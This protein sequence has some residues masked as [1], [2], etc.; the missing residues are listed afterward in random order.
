V[1]R[2]IVARLNLEFL[3]T[4]L[5]IFA[6]WQWVFTHFFALAFPLNLVWL[7]R[8][9]FKLR[10]CNVA[11]MIADLIGIQRINCSRSMSASNKL[12]VLQN[13]GFKRFGS[14]VPVLLVTRNRTESFSVIAS[15][16]GNVGLGDCY[17]SL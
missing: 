13:H 15:A 17:I 2:F 7:R 10:Q 3:V 4:Y 14:S 12:N 9:K 16:P 5:S 8:S 11:F 1:Q 6:I